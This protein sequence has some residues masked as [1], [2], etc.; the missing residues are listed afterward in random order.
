M[1]EVNQLILNLQNL[2]NEKSNDECMEAIE[3]SI[4]DAYALGREDGKEINSKELENELTKTK[5]KLR[6]LQIAQSWIDSPDRMGQ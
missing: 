3:S 2:I 1:E 4:L 5:N 6:E